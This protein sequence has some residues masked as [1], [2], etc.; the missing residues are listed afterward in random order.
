MYLFTV[1]F[2]HVNFKGVQSVQRSG[3]YDFSDDSVEQMPLERIYRPSICGDPPLTREA[4]E[5]PIYKLWLCNQRTLFKL[6]GLL[7]NYYMSS[8][9][10]L[11][12]H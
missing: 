1:L 7:K 8:I 4:P 10:R 3:S 6:F 2:A 12:C 5:V 9:V 11:G